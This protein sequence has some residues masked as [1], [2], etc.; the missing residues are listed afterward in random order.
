MNSLER[1]VIIFF[2]LVLVIAINSL[3]GCAQVPV[4]E[5]FRY[6]PLM[7][8]H[9]EIVFLLDQENAVKLIQLIEGL[10]K[11]SCRLED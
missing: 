6:Q 9:G 11:D 2:L 10:S 7:D 3:Q 5:K 4:C 8:N 1:W